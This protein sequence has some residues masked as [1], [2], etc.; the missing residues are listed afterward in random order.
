MS[1]RNQT[2]GSLADGTQVE[3]KPRSAKGLD[4]G[5]DLQHYLSL[6]G[7]NPTYQICID[8]I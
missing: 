8:W 4:R 6:I 5:H 2:W 1:E 3:T 7:L